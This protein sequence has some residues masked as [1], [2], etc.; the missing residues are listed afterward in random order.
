[1][2]QRSSSLLLGG[3]DGAWRAGT[4]SLPAVIWRVS[5]SG[6]A[7]MD[8]ELVESFLAETQELLDEIEPQIIEIQ[9]AGAQ[10]GGA[11]LDT[12]NSI[13]RLFHSMKGS[14][15]FLGLDRVA[16]V[17][18][19]AETLLDL[20]RKGRALMG[21]Q[22]A[23]VLLQTLDLL[24]RYLEEI[25]QSGSDHGLDPDAEAITALLT[26][27]VE[28]LLCGGDCGVGTEAAPEPNSEASP[29]PEPAI[30]APEPE[31]EV[32]E[33]AKEEGGGALFCLPGDEEDAPPDSGPAPEPESPDLEA[34]VINDA[35][36]SSFAQEAEEQLERV[37]QS[38]LSLESAAGD[39]LDNAMTEAFR[40]MHSLKGNAG[41]MGFVLLEGVAHNF[42][43]MLDKLKSGEL[44]IDSAR[45]TLLLEIVD[46][47]RTATHCVL[48]GESVDPQK[49][50]EIQAQILASM[51][52][53]EGESSKLAAAEDA[54]R[55]AIRQPN[56][57]GEGQVLHPQ[58]KP[59][60][61]ESAASAKAKTKAADKALNQNIRV[62]LEKLDALMNLI[63]ELVIAEAMVTRHPHIDGCE[64]ESMERAVHQLRRVSR[65]LQDVS[66]SVR[67]VPLAGTFRKMIRLVHD[68]GRKSGK[69]IELELA[70]EETEV[71]KT[72]IEQISDP[73]VHIV[74]NSA[75]HGVE[76]GDEREAAGKPKTGHIRIEGRHEGG[77]VWIL[78]TDDGRGLHRDKILSKA[79]ERGLVTGTGEELDDDQVFKLIFE[80][81]FSTASQVTDISGRGVGM[82]VVKKNIEK[83]KGKIDVQ[84]RPG[85]GTTMTLRIP[86]T[87][88]II[89]G[90]LVRVGSARYTIPLNP[91]REAFRPQADQVTLTPEG[92]E[93]VRIRDEFF[94]VLRL[95]ERF[96]IEPDSRDLVDGTLLLIEADGRGVALLVDQILG[97]QETVIKG[98]SDFLGE[99]QGVSGCTILGDGEVSLILDV[100]RL[101]EEGSELVRS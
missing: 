72:V 63:G 79:I 89:D 66:M 56:A 78:I 73:L 10:D 58:P 18:H 57:A 42:E 23:D 20:F 68:L 62:N 54:P 44:P 25:A 32:Q 46:W 9:E 82:D 51:H 91:I 15:G 80:P 19:E 45:T 21:A 67:M 13:F 22:H 2:A 53:A 47:L 94:P 4:G 52:D 93:I 1:M 81:G 7:M 36:R 31:L 100:Q 77:E 96:R 35:M 99:S 34:P 98:L 50:E 14:A 3:T 38:L 61:E 26:D 27:T 12:L 37:E 17:T 60:S 29:E 49:A 70:G 55:A 95:H 59:A 69:E 43:T 88:A 11:D 74:R 6:T 84:S 30:E 65:E 33:D 40:S 48:E 97:Q 8:P 90:M 87:L 5:K 64:I 83:L 101:F 16:G 85:Q 28:E 86:L 71:D 24:R 75:D 92:R 76:P 39:E 41:F